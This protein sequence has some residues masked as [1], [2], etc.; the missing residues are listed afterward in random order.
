MSGMRAAAL[1]ALLAV[2]LGGCDG[3]KEQRGDGLNVVLVV[4]DD[5]TYDSLQ[6]M[7]WLSARTDWS[8]V[9]RAY[10]NQPWCCP[11]RASILSGQYA[12]HHGVI[13]N[14]RFARDF[15]DSNT[16][17]TSL[18]EAGYETALFGKY[19]NGFPWEHGDSYVPPGWDRW[20]AFL[21][22]NGA[23]YDYSL[24]IDGAEVVEHG[25]E[26]SDYSTSVFARRA[27]DFVATAPEPFFAMVTPYGP[28][29]PTTPAPGD[30]GT[31]ASEPVAKPPNYGVVAPDQPAYYR[32]RGSGS[33]A[34][35]RAARREAWEATLAV[36]RATRDLY[37]ALD[38][39]G[40]LDRTVFVYMSDNGFSFG[41][42][43]FRTKN[44]LYEECAR[45]PMVI[46]MPGG[47]ARTVR[48]PISN[49]D[50]APTI[51]AL[52]GAEP[53]QDVDGQDLSAQLLSEAPW[54]RDRDLLLEVHSSK[55]GVPEGYAIVNSRW[56]YVENETGET[57]LYDLR[58]DPYELEN[59]AGE[60][61]R[62]EVES[63]LAERLAVL[64]PE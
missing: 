32:E 64:A 13:G 10:A 11:S 5:Q 60:P 55:Q 51:A 57:E 27:S 50:L 43:R 47:S 58:A 53:P 39:R 28:H 4:S 17:A 59:L 7:P 15:D 6:K 36:D 22:T 12:H 18:D 31:F 2:G 8:R 44:C 33:F 9:E 38:E 16:L 49:V 61:S 34:E 25:D 42:H 35:V 48:A 26:P 37:R 19:L 14:S 29:E 21:N 63:T 45:V 62:A 1:C 41:S 20:S 24:G 54:P 30:R 46:R 3:S 56:K 23:Y 52:A 40:L